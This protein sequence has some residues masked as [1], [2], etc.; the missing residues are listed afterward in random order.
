MCSRTPGCV[1]GNP[2]LN[3]WVDP[4]SCTMVD[5]RPRCV[6]GP[7]DVFWDIMVWDQVVLGCVPRCDDV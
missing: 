7:P 6:L 5:E 4:W 1:L 2:Y 3:A